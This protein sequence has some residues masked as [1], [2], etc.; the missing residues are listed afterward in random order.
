[1]PNQSP[2]LS[3]LEPERPIHVITV[4]MTTEI[5]RRVIRERPYSKYGES[6]WGGNALY[7]DTC[8]LLSNEAKRCLMCS[9]PTITNFLKSDICPDC[10]GR[11]EFFSNR[12]VLIGIT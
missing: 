7:D 1:M 12:S 10:D 3:L 4:G 6:R 11:T 8:L 5:A 2:S 9:A